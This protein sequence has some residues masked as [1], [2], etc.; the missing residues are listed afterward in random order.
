[1]IK[2]VGIVQK[3]NRWIFKRDIS[4]SLLTFTIHGLDLPPLK[5]ES[6]IWARYFHLEIW[7]IYIF[8]FLLGHSVYYVAC[9]W[10][11]CVSLNYCALLQSAY[12]FCY[13]GI[14][15]GQRYGMGRMNLAV[16]TPKLPA[17]TS[18]AFRESEMRVCNIRYTQNAWQTCTRFDRLSLLCREKRPWNAFAPT[19]T[20]NLF[21]SCF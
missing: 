14:V 21:A 18:H 17:I 3:M 9:A 8:L 2:K 7:G 19:P 11:L 13:S 20:D 4:L 15:Y 16:Q 6:S 12:V 1:M 5:G 10:L